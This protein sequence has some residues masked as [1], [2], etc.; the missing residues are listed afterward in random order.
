MGY[1]H[2]HRFVAFAHREEADASVGL[3]LD[4]LRRGADAPPGFAVCG[5]VWHE[6]E[7]GRFG[8]FRDASVRGVGVGGEDSDD[9]EGFD[10]KLH[11]FLS[12]A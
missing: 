6:N 4:V 3:N 12:I 5:I 11:S 9:G 8:P 1:R 2:Q 7:I 10:G